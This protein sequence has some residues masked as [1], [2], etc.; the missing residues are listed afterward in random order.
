MAKNVVYCDFTD[1]AKTMGYKKG[2]NKEDGIILG[3][4]RDKQNWRVRWVGIQ[5]IY[6]YE[7]NLIKILT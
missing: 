4:T 6:T 2:G 1:E 5:A 7:K 3:E